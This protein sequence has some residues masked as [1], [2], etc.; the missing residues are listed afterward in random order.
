MWHDYSF[1]Q[2]NKTTKR[3]GSRGWRLESMR[4]VCWTKFEI[5]G[6]RGVGNIGES[7]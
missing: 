7:S 4:I 2:R 6:G 1:S 5:G 3:A